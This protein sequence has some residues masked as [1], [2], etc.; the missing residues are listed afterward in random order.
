MALETIGP[1]R[2][3]A[4]VAVDRATVTVRAQR[5][6]E[7]AV[8][9]KTVKPGL[10]NPALVARQLE[11][12]A[13]LAATLRHPAL[14]V[15]V[16]LVRLDD[17]PALV[18]VDAGGHR[19]DAVLARARR[20]EPAVALAIVSE[21]AAALGVVHRAG[22]AHGA[23][24][25]GLVEV[26]GQGAIVLHEPLGLAEVPGSLAEP[27][28]MAPEQIVGEAADPRSD[29]FRLGTLLYTLVVGREPF[30]GDGEGISQRIRH[31]EPPRLAG[32]APDA[33]PG[34]AR[35]VGRCLAKR[36]HDRF[37]DMASLGAFLAREL[38]RE[39]SLP[40]DLLVARALAAAALAPALPGPAEVGAARGTAVPRRL[41][42]QL[43]AGGALLVGVLVALGL[44]TRSSEGPLEGA[45]GPRGI[46][47][48]PAHVRVLARPWAE[49]FV[50]G[51]RIDVT[52]RAAPIDLKPGRHSLVFRHP[53]APDEK[54]I[55][56]V[57]AG[58]V[59]LVDVAMNLRV[60]GPAPSATASPSAAP[61]R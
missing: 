29:V 60:D 1:Y 6:K 34:L 58:Q 23:L 19:L 35:I 32:L 2:V 26:T 52:P 51:Q 20:L 10:T 42:R 46:V 37:P 7:P 5:G 12:E 44:S 17:T 59:L 18:F 36:R 54:R 33:S 16:E 24:H 9:V 49:V 48:E 43:L 8:L 11:R 27:R 4:Q 3:L 57:V 13:E 38:R 45:E 53:S 15:L 41:L 61:R 56:E 22:H 28:H 21:V 14:P 47:E 25:A 50:D 31:Q 55:V 30:E 39:T 40:S